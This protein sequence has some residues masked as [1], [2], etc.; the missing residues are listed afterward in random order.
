MMLMWLGVGWAMMLLSFIV[1]I[2][3]NMIIAYILRYLFASFTTTLPWQSCQPEWIKY[4]CYDRLQG[5]QNSTGSNAT[6]FNSS[7]TS[8]CMSMLLDSFFTFAAVI[9]NGPVPQA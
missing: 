3:Y 9:I 8:T 4:G 5:V 6:L 1:A 7:S 2:Y